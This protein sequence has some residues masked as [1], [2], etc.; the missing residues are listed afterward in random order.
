MNWLPPEDNGG[1]EITNYIIQYRL[2]DRT[3]WKPTTAPIP[4]SPYTVKELKEDLEYV[5]KVAAENV[6]G[7]GD[8]SPESVPV[9][10]SGITRD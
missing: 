6:A 2:A 5:F 4:S 8:F 3:F 10:M 7:V 1:A 9:L